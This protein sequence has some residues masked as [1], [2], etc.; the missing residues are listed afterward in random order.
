MKIQVSKTFANFINS[1][2]INVVD[3]VNVVYLTEKQYRWCVASDIWDAEVDFDYK[4]GKYKAIR[5]DYKPN[6]YANP[7][8]ISTKMLN[9]MYRR[10]NVHTANDLANAL[11]HLIEI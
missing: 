6:C 5:I 11:K 1:L 4:T 8:L 10:E 2:K 9:D 7:L 3:D